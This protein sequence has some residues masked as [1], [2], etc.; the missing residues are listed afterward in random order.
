MSGHWAQ[1]YLGR[2]WAPGAAGPDR[3]DCW[4]LFRHVQRTHYGRDLPEILV[5][6]LSVL[7]CVRA[8]DDQQHSGLWQEVE[9][10]QDGDAVVMAQGRIPTHIGIW[11]DVDGGRVL[12]A[13]QGA[14]VIASSPQALTSMGWTH[15]RYYRYA[16]GGA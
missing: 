12:H 10:P 13:Q 16:G 8:I 3:F 11:I 15:R 9:H 7:S 4:G 2:P 1:Q 5:D 6:P 14:G